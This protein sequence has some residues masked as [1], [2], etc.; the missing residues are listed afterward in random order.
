MVATIHDWLI[1]HGS[2]AEI[3]SSLKGRPLAPRSTPTKGLV[4]MVR[5]AEHHPARRI[6]RK[7]PPG[8]DSLVPDQG[9]PYDLCQYLA[10]RSLRDSGQCIIEL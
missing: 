9:S 7:C 6:S 5:A 3:A 1:Q 10:Q 2:S 8:T 4:Q